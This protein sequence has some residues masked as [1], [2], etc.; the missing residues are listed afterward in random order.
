ME[1]IEIKKNSEIKKILKAEEEAV[2][3]PEAVEPSAEKKQEGDRKGKDKKFAFIKDD[4]E[5]E[6]LKVKEEAKKE[7][8]GKNEQ[9][10]GRKHNAKGGKLVYKLNEEKY[11]EE[12]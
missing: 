8:S 12:K 11:P 7:T 10:D 4:R 6:Y 9:D 5:R 2:R 3:K 1:Y